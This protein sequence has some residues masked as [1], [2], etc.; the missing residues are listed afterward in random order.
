MYLQAPGKCLVASGESLVSTLTH[1]SYIT[2]PESR[3]RDAV[4][5]AHLGRFDGVAGRPDAPLPGRL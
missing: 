4:E 1:R 2:D 3:V 5:M